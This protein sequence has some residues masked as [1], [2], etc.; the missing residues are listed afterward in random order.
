MTET[1]PFNV[2]SHVGMSEFEASK[3]WQYLINSS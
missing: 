1:N 3:I 2:S